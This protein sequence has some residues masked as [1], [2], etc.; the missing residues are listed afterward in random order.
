MGGYGSGR[1]GGRLVVEDCLSL[2]INKLLRDGLL[3]PGWRVAPSILR[4]TETRTGRETAAMAF[5]ADL[6]DPG[7][8]WM[9]LAFGSGE[10]ASR[11]EHE[12]TIR[13]AT[14]RPRFGGLRWWFVCPLSGRR[15]G[16]LHLPHGASVFASRQAWRLDYHSQRLSPWEREMR[17]ARDRASRI[18]RR[19]GGT[20]TGHAA[21]HED[22]PPRQRG[23]WRSTYER[24]QRELDEAGR[25]AEAAE[26]T[27]IEAIV[28][29][30]RK[31]RAES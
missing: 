24:L 28:D 30:K 17:T 1:Q 15:C 23:M 12:C 14:T 8:A 21:V 3:V 20:V 2:D 25:R 29:P 4:W 31:R 16:T 5:V 22:A 18:R 9:R 13:L 27:R 11:R 6:A 10:G 19:L 26:W 7:A